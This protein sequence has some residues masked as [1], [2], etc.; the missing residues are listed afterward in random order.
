MVRFSDTFH[1]SRR[2]IKGCGN[3]SIELPT[4]MG[5]RFSLFVHIH[6]VDMNEIFMASKIVMIVVLCDE[7]DINRWI[8][9]RLGSSSNYLLSPGSSEV[10]VKVLRKVMFMVIAACII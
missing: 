8:R 7:W 10:W 6:Y 5:A 4:D 3:S 1:H 2:I 9:C